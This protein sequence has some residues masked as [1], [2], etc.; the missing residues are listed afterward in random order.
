MTCCFNSPAATKL[1]VMEKKME[2]DLPIVVISVK[3]YKKA[4]A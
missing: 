3:E 2:E 4:E 1:V